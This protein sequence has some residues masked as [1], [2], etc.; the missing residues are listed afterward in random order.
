MDRARCLDYADD[1]EMLDRL[2]FAE[3]SGKP[4]QKKVPFTAV[5]SARRICA[6]CPVRQDCLER[7]LDLE[8]AS[9]WAVSWDSE[10]GRVYTREVTPE[11]DGMWGGILKEER[12]STRDMPRRERLAALDAIFEEESTKVL[13]PSE[14]VA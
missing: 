2:L 6:A 12:R 9:H 11:V 7:S 13:L 1:F 5:G 14:R 4:G 3:K 10:R 8:G